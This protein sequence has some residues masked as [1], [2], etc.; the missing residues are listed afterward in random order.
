MDSLNI[1]SDV[2]YNGYFLAKTLPYPSLPL[3]S[4]PFILI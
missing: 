2:W 3:D 1:G 4:A